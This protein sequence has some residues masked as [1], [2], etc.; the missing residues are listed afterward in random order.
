MLFS[1]KYAKY[2]IQIL[3]KILLK[4]SEV[5]LLK[6]FPPMMINNSLNVLMLLLMTHLLWLGN[7]NTCESTSSSVLS[8]YFEGKRVALLPGSPCYKS[9]G[10]CDHFQTCRLLD[11]DGPIARL[12]NFH[13]KLHKYDDLADWMK[14]WFALEVYHTTKH[15]FALLSI[16]TTIYTICRY[17]CS[18]WAKTQRFALELQ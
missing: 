4:Y 18:R 10:Y 14:V 1:G 5:H 7:P 9:Q 16:R 8:T 13:L 11:A 6:Y 12:K 17:K 2:G 15:C 3:H